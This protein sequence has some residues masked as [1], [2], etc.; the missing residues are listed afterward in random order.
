MNSKLS[1]GK[2]KEHKLR[3][4]LTAMESVTFVYSLATEQEKQTEAFK[5][6]EQHQLDK[7]RALIEKQMEKERAFLS[8]KKIEFLSRQEA[9]LGGKRRP[10]S[11]P[12][13]MGYQLPEMTTKSKQKEMLHKN[14]LLVAKA[15]TR[16]IAQ[17]ISHQRTHSG[18]MV[19]SSK[20]ISTNTSPA[21]ERKF[22][23]VTFTGSNSPAVDINA[24]NQK[25]RKSPQYKN[26]KPLT[27]EGPNEI[28][29]ETL[30]KRKSTLAKRENS[31][32][33]L[34]KAQKVKVSKDYRYSKEK[35]S[36]DRVSIDCSRKTDSHSFGKAEP[37]AATKPSG[38][39][40]SWA[41]VARVIG[42]KTKFKRRRLHGTFQAPELEVL[43]Q[44]LRNDRRFGQAKLND[45]WKAVTGCRY[46]RMPI[47]NDT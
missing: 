15:E 39:S 6:H 25:E 4:E 1:G 45:S 16:N 46:L 24:H 29:N 42:L 11:V 26:S 37:T 28:E 38:G 40:V 18:M 22:C 36:K 2:K 5:N 44:S 19:A 47:R 34:T 12:A 32:N 30:R 3:L 27:I 21:E 41:V 31:Q 9:K 43:D 23:L 10:L 14:G 33:K 13:R 7:Y 20:P 17:F 8:Y 35:E